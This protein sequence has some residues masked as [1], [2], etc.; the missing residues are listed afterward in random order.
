MR[1]LRYTGMHTSIERDDAPYDVLLYSCCTAANRLSRHPRGRLFPTHERLSKDTLETTMP[2][3]IVVE[4]PTKAKTIGR[5]LGAQYRVVASAGHVRDL[6]KKDLGYDAET[7]EPHYEVITDKKNAV[8]T[9]KDAARGVDEVLIATDPDREGEAIGWHVAALLGLKGDVKRLEF[10][11]ITQKAIDAALA[12][13]IR[14]IASALGRRVRVSTEAFPAPAFAQVDPA[15][16]EATLLALCLAA[17]AA[18]PE[19]GL[20]ALTAQTSNS[21]LAISMTATGPGLSHL[22][23]NQARCIA[24]AAGLTIRLG[25]VAVEAEVIIPLPLR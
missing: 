12:H 2:K 15:G 20:I 6:P 4:S 13:P 24:A 8:K 3:L 7:F 1:H 21:F 17:R 11:E 9:L 22:D 19:A 16:L 23:L 25:Q 18:I 5:F 14:L 10:H